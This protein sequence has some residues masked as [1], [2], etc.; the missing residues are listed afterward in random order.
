MQLIDPVQQDSTTTL[1]NRSLILI[2][3]VENTVTQPAILRSIYGLCSSTR[4]SIIVVIRCY[5]ILGT[6]YVS[7]TVVFSFLKQQ[8]MSVCMY[9]LTWSVGCIAV[10][11]GSLSVTGT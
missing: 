3:A 9:S 5:D 4:H 10:V 11:S 8:L 1:Q 2:S 7:K 6:Y